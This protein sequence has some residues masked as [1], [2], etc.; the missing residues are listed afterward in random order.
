MHCYEYTN[1]NPLK[2]CQLDSNFAAGFF[3]PK[4][5]AAQVNIKA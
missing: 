3:P 5:Q 4:L 2:D 1:L